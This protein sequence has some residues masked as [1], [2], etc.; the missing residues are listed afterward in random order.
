MFCAKLSS[1]IFQWDRGDYEL[2]REAKEG[3]LLKQGMHPTEKQ[4]TAA[5]KPAELA[6]HCR[7]HTRPVEDI[8]QLVD[9]LLVEMW[10]KTDTSGL[11]LI[12]PEAMGHIWALQQK[13][14]PCIQD[15]EG[16]N[17]YTKTGTLEKGG[18]HLQVLR[19]A[20]GTSSLESFH[21]HQCSFI[22]GKLVF[23]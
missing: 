4:V 8:R 19:C 12:N 16:I 10:D 2:L 22:P 3:E 14:L 15:P 7:R 13:H 20:R 11:R 6:Q 5:I 18:K 17:L 9:Q 1:C 23:L 21:R